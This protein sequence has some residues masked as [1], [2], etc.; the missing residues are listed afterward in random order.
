[1]EK[2][3]FADTG[4]LK[5]DSWNQA[6]G[7]KIQHL[8]FVINFADKQ[9][10]KPCISIDS[11]LDKLFDLSALKEFLD[12]DHYKDIPLVYAEEDAFRTNRLNKYIKFLFRNSRLKKSLKRSYEENLVEDKLLG[13]NFNYPAIRMIGHFWHYD[14][15]PDLAVFEKYCPIKEELIN[16]VRD[17]Y[18]TLE[19]PKSF[20]VHYRGTDFKNHLRQIF[21]TPICLPA[22]YYM[23]ATKTVEKVLGEDIEYHLFSDEM[24][25][26]TDIFKDKKIIVHKDDLYMDWCALFLSK[27]MISS[28]SSFCWTASL[29][30]KVNLIQPKGGYNHS[31]PEHPVPYGFNIPGSCVI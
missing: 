19:S 17:H 29:Y 28:N 25:F 15:M 7:N 1:M 4:R 23:N 2:K 14:L 21:K 26:L 22:E 10:I 18:P 11:N 12:D 3:I 16:R 8:L 13:T 31:D 20:A 6:L 5:F 30:N 24:D 9:N 27:N